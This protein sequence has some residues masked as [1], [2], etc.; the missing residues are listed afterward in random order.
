MV[1][2]YD[3]LLRY[4]KRLPL[5]MRRKPWPVQLATLSQPVYIRIGGVDA[6]VLEEIYG[7]GVYNSVLSLP[8]GQ[9]NTVLDCGANIGL[10]VRLWLEHFPQAR[11]VAVEPSSINLPML[12]RN[13]TAAAEGRDRVSVVKACVAGAPGEVFLDNT[14]TEL[15]FEMSHTPVANGE[16]VPAKPVPQILD[17]AGIE[18][19]IDLMKCDIEGA[20]VEVF[21]DCSA[22]IS[23]VR[24][25]FAELHGDYTIQHLIDDLTRGGAKFEVA[26]SGDTFGNPLVFLRRA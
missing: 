26:W 10:S 7:D 25:L 18:G 19:D 8:P 12:E 5:P 6:V 23:R 4:A 3:T 15:A 20:E 9:V 14:N 11:V 17:E 21:R 24:N 22:W 1:S 16:S 13:I 2:L